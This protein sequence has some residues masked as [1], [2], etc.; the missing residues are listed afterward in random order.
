M[1]AYVYKSLKK[2]DTYLY[3]ATRDDFGSSLDD[4]SAWAGI[5]YFAS[6][7]RG[8]SADGPFE[9]PAAFLTRRSV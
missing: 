7:L 5:H 2:A 8:S 9:A 1:L 3:L 6:R 4:T